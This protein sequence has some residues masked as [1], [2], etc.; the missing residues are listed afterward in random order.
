MSKV[1]KATVAVNGVE[2]SV[3]TARKEIACGKCLTPTKGRIGHRAMC[4]DCGMAEL[5]KPI[6][7]FQ[8]RLKELFGRELL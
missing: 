8:C 3:N 5:M 4:V 6:G 2:W 7:D 1:G